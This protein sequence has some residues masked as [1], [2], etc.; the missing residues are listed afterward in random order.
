MNTNENTWEEK[1]DK[2]IGD[3]AIGYF[4]SGQAKKDVEFGLPS[5]SFY[6]NF[7]G[8]LIPFISQEIQRAKEEAYKELAKIFWLNIQQCITAESED[9]KTLF[10]RIDAED[11]KSK[12]KSIKQQ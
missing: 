2:I 10:L 6:D 3:L 8:K 11:F 7:K 4:L 12:L 1:L 5:N 9:K